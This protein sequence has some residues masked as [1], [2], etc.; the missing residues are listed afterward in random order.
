MHF[1]NIYLRSFRLFLFPLALVYGLIVKL[2]NWMFTKNW[3]GSVTFNLPIISV[4]NLTVGGTGKSPMVEYLAALL[5]N[6]FPLATLSR[7][8]K[9]RTSGYLLAGP[10]STAIEIGDEP[11]QFHITH[12][13]ISVAVGEKR[14]EAIPQLLFDRPATKLIILDDAFQHREIHAGL[15]VL[16]TDY[17]NL[18]TR[19]FFLPTGDLRD[20]VQSAK[21][22][23]ILVVTKCPPTL[24]EHE[25]FL[26]MKELNPQKH[27]EVFFTSIE[28]KTPYHIIT[29]EKRPLSKTEEVLLVCGIANPEPL[30]SY[31]HEHTKTYDALFYSDHHLFNV[32]DISDIKE[33]FDRMN[34]GNDFILTT[35]KDAVRILKFENFLQDLPF[36]VLPISIHFLFNQKE[37]FDEL[38]R[39]YP[40]TFYRKQADEIVFENEIEEL[41]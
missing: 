31:I 25:R 32:D 19:D 7:G 36:Y 26:I 21:R 39:S 17:S 5:K 8:Y 14:I 29:K 27:Q 41:H 22:A 4:G 34:D 24:S 12:P 33:R 35:E 38:I 23:D 2:R 28:Y 37:Q 3:I 30:T 11:M 13:D 20:E 9:R 18:Y 16:L 40:Q 15:E 10:D 1:K 6:E